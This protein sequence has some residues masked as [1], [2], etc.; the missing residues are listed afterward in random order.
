M[1]TLI[2]ENG[3]KTINDEEFREND[4]E[5]IIIPDSVTSIGTQAFQNSK[6]LKKVT[7]SKNLKIL[8]DA[9]FAGCSSLE[10]VEI[11]KSLTYIPRVC[12]ADCI[13]L[14]KVITHDN[15]TYFD[16]YAFYK[17][18]N[19]EEFSLPANLTY[20]GIKSLAKCNKIK[21]LT[22]PSTLEDIE[23]AAFSEMQSLMNI[24]VDNENPRYKSFDG[25]SLVDTKDNVLVQYAIANS[26]DEY[27]VY[28]FP[29]QYCLG[30][31]ETD[32]HITSTERFYHIAD[33]AFAGAKNLRTLNITGAIE[34]IGAN[35]FK[36]LTCHN[37]NVLNDAYSD[38]IIFNMGSFNESPQ[39]PFTNITF[40]EGITT[41]SSGLSELF[42]NAR[43]VKL[44]TS[45]K[46]IG[47]NV[48]RKSKY[49]KDLEIPK[50]IKSIDL[51]TF[52]DDIT[53]HFE[54]L[55]NIKAKYFLM[56][57]TKSSDESYL[58]Y[59]DK[60]NTRIY[61][62]KDGTY[63]VKVDDYG[64]IEIKKEDIKRFSKNSELV[65]EE[66]DLFLKYFFKLSYLYANYSQMFFDIF[67]NKNIYNS[68]NNFFNDLG[69]IEEITDQKI[70]DL[71]KV[72]LEDNDHYNEL[73]LNGLFMR[74]ISKGELLYIL[75]NMNPALERFLTKT[76]YLK[77]FSERSYL[78]QKY[79]D[80]SFIVNYCKLL[81]KYDIKDATLFS[82]NIA[83]KLA[84][85]DQELLLKYY[86]KNIKKLLIKSEAL[87]TPAIVDLINLLKILGA[88]TD[89]AILSQKVTTFLMEKIVDKDSDYAI[90]GSDIHRVFNEIIVRPGVDYEFIVFF[91][92]NYKDLINYEKSNSGFIAKIYN[93]FEEIK[94]LSTSNRGNIKRIKVTLDKCLYYFLIKTFNN[95]NDN[96]KDLA[97]FL[98]KFYNEDD[99]L[100]KAEE[101]IN[102]SNNAMRNIFTISD[103]STDDIKGN[104]KGYNY[105]WLPKQDW[106][107]LVLGKLCNC[108]AHICGKG[109]GIM[110][111]SMINNDVQ[112][113][114][115][116]DLKNQIIAKSTLYINRQEGYGVINTVEINSLVPDEIK[117]DIIYPALMEGILKLVEVY[118]LNNPRPL[119][120][121][122]VGT[123]QNCLLKVLED[124]NHQDTDLLLPIN[125]SE[126]QYN[127]NNREYGSYNGDASKRQLL[128]YKK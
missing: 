95:V 23:C 125:Y 5:E 36:S 38:N 122:T 18:Y 34:S 116:R 105:E 11:P 47:T 27:T 20:V 104:I 112:N 76:D 68:F 82:D 69:S 8:G 25:L 45:L 53:L 66:P 41:L 102:I 119:T 46:Q 16:H 51:D 98:S 100:T 48:F 22:L 113:F 110:L 123:N 115:V 85:Q 40:E 81:E 120:R 33:Y 35:S 94:K 89:D 106:Y 62:L 30:D 91:I 56:M 29:V 9:A 31:E 126:Y 84:Y 32:V 80:L 79:Y 90:I 72:I 37:L 127:I 67:H 118:N 2:I 28:N 55:M 65:S 54:D 13:N 60:D 42:K 57:Q 108:C 92:E 1:K 17:C 99:V 124:H 103:D 93:N 128:L 87:D 50:D 24:Q 77:V 3:R 44:P 78:D 10:S 52:Y 109:A 71:I 7:L 58:S 86:N 19:L 49:L 4:Y 21:S 121:I 64:Y 117:E 107:N 61:S 73:F 43:F 15:I 74:N 114:V 75:E 14:K 111:A 101:I 39:I 63:Y 88:F 12:F 97:L 6:K 59:F 83:V 96:N 70:K 26:Q